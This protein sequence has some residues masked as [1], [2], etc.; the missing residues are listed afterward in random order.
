VE[1]KESNQIP[2]DRSWQERFF[3]YTGILASFFAL[4]LVKSHSY[5]LFHSLVEVFSIVIAG[6]IFALTWNARRYFDNGYILLIGISFLFIGFI[7][8]IH[9]L[10]Y[11]GMGVYPGYDSDLPT[12]LWIAARWLQALSFFAATFFLDR[13]LN[14]PLMVL[15]G[16]TVVLILLFLSIFY[17]NIF[18][19]C[20]VEGT[21]LTPFKIASEYGISLILLISIVPLTK[22]K[23][24][25]HP[26]V[27]QLIIASILSTVA[28]EMSFT[29]YTDAYGFFNALGHFFKVIAFI[30]IYKAVVSIGLKQ[31]Y[32]LLFRD[33][34]IRQDELRQSE[35]RY[36]SLF[37]HMLNG[38]AY[39]KMEF[40][41]DGRPVDFIYLAVNDAFEKLTGLKN[42]EGKRITE[43]MPSIR[44]DNPEFLELY[45]R[46][47]TTGQPEK[48]E[49]LLKPLDL[50]LYIS[51]YSVEKENFVAV[52]ENITE[53]RKAE[54]DYQSIFENVQEGVFRS[55][56][57]GK[58]ILA[59]EAMA[60]MFGYDSP[61]EIMAD[62]TDVAAQLYVHPEERASVKKII[63]EQNAIQNYEVKFHRKD[64]GA[65]WG[66]ATMK[67]I[68][69][70]K[71]QI[72][73]Y[74]GIIEDITE[75]KL[76]IERL[77]KTLGGAVQAIA[78]LVETRDPYTAGH[79]RRVADLARAIATEMG[80][81]GDQIDG[82]R[83]A[84]NIHDLGKIS[85][86]S[87]ILTI[88]RKLT[89]LEY[90]LIKNHPQSGYDI[91]KD[92]EFPWPIARMIVEHHERIN[93]SGYPNGLRGEDLLIESK[94]LSVADV[95]E[96]MATHRPYRPALGIDAALAEITANRGILY[97]PE[98]VNACLRLFRDKG[99]QISH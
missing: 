10:A 5:V 74:E 1:D 41:A 94:I 51:V 44:Q 98:V 35:E 47:A 88:P 66:S 29:L 32:D 27:R 39:C 58:I 55:T 70:G 19:S 42:V 96:A 91:L 33:L 26:R 89:A 11:K 83:I 85:V 40:D 80:L 6:A 52:F 76:S 78:S 14:R 86:P 53:R 24:K 54:K 21:G 93:G 62:I 38:M 15:I 8:L 68:R 99:Y 4:Y 81:S 18:P 65:F 34:K 36:H 50:W 37:K 97:D 2:T 9:T 30:F 72:L 48:R 61:A 92:I 77:R 73:Y 3:I 57:D 95:V 20:F 82:I 28:S 16:G 12:Q 17:W 64:G 46:V 45:G 75:R 59:N 67:A 79:Q 13:K 22:K 25:L 63:A 49:L 7:D 23:D 69:N 43:I 56:P 31:P 84:G 87:E 90:S 71:D 60:K